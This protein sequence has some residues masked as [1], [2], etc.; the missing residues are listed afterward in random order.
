MEELFR[1]DWFA[2]AQHLDVTISL[3][4]ETNR[5]SHAEAFARQFQVHPTNT[6]IGIIGSRAAP[7]SSAIRSAL[8]KSFEHGDCPFAVMVFLQT[9][10]RAA[11]S[12]S[13]V[14]AMAR[15]GA[16]R[17]PF[18]TARS[19]DEAVE[20]I[21]RRFGPRPELKDSIDRLVLSFEDAN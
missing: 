20:L 17:F 13:V 5:M 7:P 2:L 10:F 6:Y 11:F 18:T 1:D 9:G 16:I 4:V 15:L 8:M 12:R 3:V 14:T 21:E 19:T